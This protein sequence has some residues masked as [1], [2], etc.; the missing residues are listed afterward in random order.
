MS[1]SFLQNKQSLTKGIKIIQCFQPGHN[2]NI[3]SC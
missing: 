2:D 3:N 1:A